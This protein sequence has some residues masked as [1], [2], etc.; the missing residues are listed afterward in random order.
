MTDEIKKRISDNKL[1]RWF[2]RILAGIILVN[3]TAHILHYTWKEG[4]IP[5][6][7]NRWA[8]IIG[9]LTIW[10]AFEAFQEFLKRKAGQNN[11]NGR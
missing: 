7:I 3:F 4:D 10:A 5:M 1:V 8:L 6:G 2:L 11:F 9:C